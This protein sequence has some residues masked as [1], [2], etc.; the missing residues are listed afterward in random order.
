MLRGPA[1]GA[2]D[3]SLDAVDASGPD[4]RTPVALVPPPRLT[5]WPQRAAMGIALLA[6]TWLT[7]KRPGSQRVDVRIGDAVRRLSVPVLDGAV[8]ATTDL[9]SVYAVIGVSATLS[10]LGRARAAADVLGV[11]IVAWNLA[12]WNKTRVRRARPYEAEG[13]RRLIGRPTGSSFPS[14]HAAVGAAM[15]TVLADAATST[16]GRRLLQMLGAYVAFSRVYVG[17]HYPTDVIGGTGMGLAISALWRGPLSEANAR[18]LRRVW[19]LR[20]S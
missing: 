15:F 19:R 5:T 20:G 18:L 14:G 12:Q 13:T 4:E 11:G 8:T 16:P 7:L 2:A 3:Q 1:A 10:A 6:G 9:G 17:V